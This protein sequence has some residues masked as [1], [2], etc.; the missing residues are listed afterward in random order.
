M[1]NLQKSLMLLVVS[2]LVASSQ[3]ALIDGQNWADSVTSYA[4]Q[5]QNYD[6]IFMDSTTEFWVLG[7]SDADQTGNMHA[8]DFDN[9]DLDYVAGWRGG[10]A[11]QEIVVGFNT[12]LEDVV[13]DDLVIRMYC[14]SKAQATIS[15]SQDNLSWTQIG[16]ITGVSMQIPGKPGFLYDAVFDFA[17]LFSG[18]AYYVKVYRETTG[19]GSGM[20]FD[21]FASVPEPATMV[22]LGLGTVLLRRKK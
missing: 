8:W 14:G 21:S 20:F 1:K 18:D 10:S 5:I 17:G 15:V 2:A 12:A 9:G 13:G 3:A 16:N 7:Q 4:S 22:I 11:N 6:G 19:S